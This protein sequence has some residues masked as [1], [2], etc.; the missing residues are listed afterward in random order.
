MFQLNFEFVVAGFF[1][2]KCQNRVCVHLPTLVIISW[3]VCFN[4]GKGTTKIWR[5]RFFHSLIIFACCRRFLTCVSSLIF[6]PGFEF[7]FVF[8]RETT[9]MHGKIVLLHR[10]VRLN[11][12]CFSLRYVIRWDMWFVYFFNFCLDSFPVLVSSRW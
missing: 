4:Q 12:S 8:F 5:R 7:L 1:I 3:R 11:P 6:P 2:C 9:I 10:L